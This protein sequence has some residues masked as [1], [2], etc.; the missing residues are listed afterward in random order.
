MRKVIINGDDLGLS[1]GTNEGICACLQE[2]ILSSTSIMAGGAAFDD[3]VQRL[4]RLG[5]RHVGIHL[6]LDEER[7]VLP[8]SEI[9]SIVTAEGIFFDRGKLLKKLLL[10][11]A[12]QMDDVER[13][14]RAQIQKC[15]DAGLQLSH[16]DGH[17]HVHV[18][19]KISAVVAEL[20]GAFGI[21]RVRLPAERYRYVDLSAYGLGKHTNK[22]IVTTFARRARKRFLQAG[23]RF[24][25]GFMGM[26]GGG[27]MNRA[28]LRKTLARLP[29]TAHVEIM[30]HPGAPDL[31]RDKRYAHW[32]YNWDAE[33]VALTSL[34]PGELRDAFGV[35]LLPFHA[36]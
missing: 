30:C 2:G 12:I 32:H 25:E 20:A 1:I 8:P 14:F 21:S 11:N 16:I 19:P 4:Q 18:Y 33:M 24:P 13:E 29:N 7:P 15:L 35:E 5:L 34:T 28:N 23:L 3:A 27:N 22:F 10:G 26:L 36:F 9:P 17:G 31:E 6:T